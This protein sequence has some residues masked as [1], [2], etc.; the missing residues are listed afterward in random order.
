MLNH[1]VNWADLPEVETRPGVAKRQIEG[2]GASLAMIR[3]AA[4]L[5]ADRHS[6][7]HEQFVQVISGTGTIETEQGERAFGPGT[8]FHFPTNTWHAA[9]FDSETVL[10]ETNLNT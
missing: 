10:V 4:G 3:V 6:H 5:R 8:V 7:P 1:V 9:R 2:A